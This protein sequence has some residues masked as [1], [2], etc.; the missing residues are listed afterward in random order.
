MQ[1]SRQITVRCTPLCR[2]I[3]WP[4]EVLHQVIMTLVILWPRMV[5]CQVIMTFVHPLGQAD[6]WSDISPAVEASGGQ[7]WYYIRSPWHLV[8]LRARLTF[9]QMY[10]PVEASGAQEW[11]WHRSSWPELSMMSGHLDIWLAFGSDRISVRH[12]P[13]VEASSG[14]EWYEL[15]SHWP[16]LM[17]YCLQ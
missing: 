2:G 1:L 6:I 14:Q 8:I 11:Y 5:L 13:L 3:W 9:S 4:R 17:F 7:E 10:S 16:E 12:T 15:G